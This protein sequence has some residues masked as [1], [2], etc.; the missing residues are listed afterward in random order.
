MWMDEYE[1]WVS[2][3]DLPMDLKEDL[4]GKTLA[5]LEERFFSPLEFGTGGMR[6]ILG[7]GLNR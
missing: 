7:A 3:P 5:E 1:K 4:E 2:N 6:G